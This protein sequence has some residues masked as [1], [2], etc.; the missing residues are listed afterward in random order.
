MLLL[1]LKVQYWIKITVT[2]AICNEYILTVL[3]CLVCVQVL[4]LSG[5]P[6]FGV[7]FRRGSLLRIGFIAVV[8]FCYF[9]RRWLRGMALSSVVDSFV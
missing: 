3:L 6:S 8:S 1:S 9:V 7:A 5:F 2:Y 4:L